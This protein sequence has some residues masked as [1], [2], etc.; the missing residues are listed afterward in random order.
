MQAPR[1]RLM[2]EVGLVAALVVA[3]LGH[4]HAGIADSPLP[5]GFSKHVWSVVG[6]TDNGIIKTAFSCANTDKSP[7]LVGVEVFDGAGTLLNVAGVSALM[8]APGETGLFGTS[9]L[10]S[11]TADRTLGTAV[12]PGAGSARIVAN[13]TKLMCSAWLTRGD[14]MASLTI[15]KKAKQK[16][17]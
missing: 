13:T 11:H 16:G 5:V 2:V 12:H 7:T 8:L 3:V 17:D 10:S 9:S 1:R 14:A 4:A 6:V 15:T